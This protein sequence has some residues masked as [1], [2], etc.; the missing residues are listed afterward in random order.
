MDWYYVV[1]FLLVAIYWIALK[2]ALRGCQRENRRLAQA[3]RETTAT[4]LD[5]HVQGAYRRV[6]SPAFDAD[7]LVEIPVAEGLGDVQTTRTGNTVGAMKFISKVVLLAAA[8]GMLLLVLIGG[9]AM[10]MV[11]TS[12]VAGLRAVNCERAINAGHYRYRVIIV[13]GRTHPVCKR[14]T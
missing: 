7:E 9:T 12:S 2:L 14:S 4:L 6:P 11:Q 10:M 3:Y 8:A 13:W 1:L 5:S